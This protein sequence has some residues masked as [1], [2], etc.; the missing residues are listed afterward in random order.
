MLQLTLDPMETFGLDD[1]EDTGITPLCG[2]ILCEGEQIGYIEMLLIEPEHLHNCKDIHQILKQTDA[3]LLS[4][5]RSVFRSTSL[6]LRP[7]AASLGYE[8]GHILYIQSIKL[9]NTWCEQPVEIAA[10]R[11]LV[12]LTSSKLV[13]LGEY[14]AQ[15]AHTESAAERFSSIGF[16]R[17]SDHD[18]EENTLALNVD[19][20]SREHQ[21]TMRAA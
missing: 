8:L 4:V 16:R 20:L 5:W 7:A 1:V 9:T 17:I 15:S 14:T 3:R 6:S 11:R 12:R 10:L 2:R 13:L 19:W 18:T 21:E